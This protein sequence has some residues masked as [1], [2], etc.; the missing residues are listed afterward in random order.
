MEEKN[1]IKLYAAFKAG[2]LGNNILET[3]YPF[4]ASILYEN[5]SEKVDEY[6]LQENFYQKYNFKPTIPFIRQVLSIGIENGS[7][8][9]LANN[10][11][12][13]HSLLKQYVFDSSSFEEQWKKLIVELQQYYEANPTNYNIQNIEDDILKYIEK[14]D[15][16][17]ISQT[18]I[19]LKMPD[20]DSFEYLW[21]RFISSLNKLESPLLDFIASICASNIYK[22]ALF[23][24]VEKND[25]FKNLNVY[26]D[27]PMV[28]ALLGMD[29]TER[30]E[31]Y[32]L[33][34]NDMIASGCNVQVLDNN[35]SEISGIIQRSATWANS[36][37]YS[38]SRATKVAKYLHDLEMSHEEIIEYCESIEEQLN[39]LGITIKETSY[40]L[41]DATFLEDETTLF[42]MVKEKYSEHHM[43][44]SDDKSESI[45]T[46][47]RSIIMVYSERKGRTAVKVQ[48]CGHIILTI[49]GVLAN[50][51]KNYESNK[52]INSGH[53]PACIS[54]DLF[55]ALLWMFSPKSVL[56]YQ[57]SKLLADCYA[58]LQPSKQ[59]LD[60][61]IE[62]LESAKNLGE[63][64]E[65]KYLFMRSH[66]M[67]NDALM[68]VTKGDYARFNDKT[69]LDVYEE[70][71]SEAKKDYLDEAEKHTAT[72]QKLQ[73]SE[74]HN[75]NLKAEK[76]MLLENYTALK[77]DFESLKTE[78]KEKDEKQ[79]KTKCNVITNIVSFFVLFVP[80][81]IILVVLEF[82]KSKYAS[83][84][85]NA[86][87]AIIL[88]AVILGLLAVFVY[89]KL[90]KCLYAF[91]RKVLSKPL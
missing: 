26:L 40:N 8:K 27:S 70:I 91:I 85:S 88:V 77:N 84:V 32:K 50:V 22:E 67:V 39:D 15:Y 37:M 9:K 7:I 35:F 68:N 3:Y 82:I 21:V 29:S 74:E 18:E 12:A 83:E 38:I 47:V 2:Y 6:L 46:D 19:E 45:Q 34:V 55:G 75:A 90:K 59:L 71:K 16:K 41:Q 1:C 51:S 25:T 28:F 80:Y 89:S 13:D 60:K 43:G 24:T 78:Q 72:L 52:S 31:S 4:F 56:Q 66:S 49:N 23:Y 64:D 33:L 10:Y 53:I 36:T 5:H 62:S 86:H 11:I 42:N 65:K 20:V 44:I 76:D 61:Y 58:A 69:Y 57:K 87:I 63:I 81:V 30:S 54:A 17:L 48:N 14:N 73:T 79:L